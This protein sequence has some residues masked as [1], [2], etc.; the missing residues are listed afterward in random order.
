MRPHIRETH[1]GLAARCSPAPSELL[2]LAAAIKCLLGRD[3]LVRA[4]LH[5]ASPAE[6]VWLSCKVVPGG[7]R[8]DV[9]TFAHCQQDPPSHTGKGP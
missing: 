9:E 1:L 8:K 3:G 2:V 6:G 4:H 7:W 5:I